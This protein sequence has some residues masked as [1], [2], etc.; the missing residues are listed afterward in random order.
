M[1]K[2]FKRGLLV[3]V[4]GFAAL[5]GARL[6]YGYATYSSVAK[7][8][9]IGETWMASGDS[10][11]SASPQTAIGRRG[12]ID[13]SSPRNYAT[14]KVKTGGSPVI[15]QKYEKVA[16][17]TARTPDFDKDEPVL[18]EAVKRHNALI[19][20]E[21]SSG[22]SGGRSLHLAI[23]VHPDNYDS[24]VADVRQV[25]RLDSIRVDKFDKTNEY[26]ELNASRISMEKTRDSLVALKNRTGKIDEFVALEDRILEIEKE[27]QGLGV[28]LGDYDQENEFCTVRFTLAEESVIATGI[29]FAQRARVALVWTAKYYLMVLAGLFFATG[30][31]L[32]L[33]ILLERLKWVP[34]A[35][36]N[37]AAKN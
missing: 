4:L 12:N 19:Q 30:F 2:T 22:V 9:A 26:K 24:L 31:V 1:K 7:T 33:T 27:I 29:S 16:S 5:F 34:A 21:Q 17:L 11:F 3:F 6:L 8:V 35:F 36:A 18:R 10:A 23:G 28:K 15:D 20:F 25:G 13:E 14:Q 37:L 32:L